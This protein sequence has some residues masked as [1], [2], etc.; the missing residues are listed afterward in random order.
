MH[1]TQGA[2]RGT[3]LHTLE[4]HRLH[5]PVRVALTILLDRQTASGESHRLPPFLVGKLRENY[6]GLIAVS[7]QKRRQTSNVPTVTR[8]TALRSV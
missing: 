8:R 1:S 3:I 4:A 6:Q 2:E 5:K 7:A